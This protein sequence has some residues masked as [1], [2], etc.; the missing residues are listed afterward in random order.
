MASPGA[1]SSS[2]AAPRVLLVDDDTVLRGVLRDYLQRD[3]FTVAV[4]GT[5]SD[6]VAGLLDVP[7]ALAPDLLLLDLSLPGMDGL[8]VFRR[9]RAAGCTVPVIMLTART[10]EPERVLGLEI[11]ADDYVSK[12]C[13]PR[14]VVLRARSVLRRAA[15]R[16]DAA[17]VPVLRDGDLVLDRRAGTAHRGG[18]PLSLT[19]REF[20]LLE[21]FLS[22]PGELLERD[23]ILR[24]VWRW[25]HGDPS[26][27]TVHVRRLREKVEADPACPQR[28]LTVWGRGYRWEPEA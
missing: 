10:E 8:E 15:P 2:D 9:V 22:R 25:E 17:G 28:I 18:S 4:A 26:T 6:A 23:Q 12:P 14:E 24:E 13:S 16:E 5:G 19:P 1:G 7:A 11:G 20:A 3:G 21:R 27:I